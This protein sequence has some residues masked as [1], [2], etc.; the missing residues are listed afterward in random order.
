MPII[1]FVIDTSAS[2][3]QRTYMGTTLLDVAKGAVETFLKLR[4]RD[5][6]SRA[7]RYMLVSFEDPP[8]AIKA[9][10]KEN[11]V[12]FMNE[13][14]NLQATGMTTMGQALKQ[15]FDLL[16]LNRL[17][18]GIDNYGQGRNP[19]FLE[20]AM[21]VTI[22]DGSK[23]TSSS[24]VQEELTLP[25]NSQLPGGELTKEPFRWDQRLFSLV[26]RIP[27]VACRVQEPPQGV[28][29]MDESPI[30]V[31]CEITGGRSYTVASQKTL[32][33]CL[34]SLSM[35]VQSGVVLHFEKIGPDP[36]P[37]GNGQNHTETEG[38][39][40]GIISADLTHLRAEKD[41]QENNKSLQRANAPSPLPTNTA[42]H[43]CHKLI[44]VR[45]NPKTGIPMGHWPIP[46]AFWPDSNA[47]TLLPR[48]AHP[49]VKFTCTNS[50][51]MVIDN[52]PFDKY[53][54]EP[55]PLTQFILERK[56]PTTCWQCFVPSSGRYSDIGHPF[57]YLKASMS[58]TC[59]NLFIMPYNYP[60]LLPLLDELF[61]VHK[62]KPNAKWRTAFDNYL[63]SMPS[64][65][66]GPLKAALRR[67][68]APQLIPDHLDMCLSYSV[69]SY[70]KK[71]KQQAKLE[72]DRII[73]SVGKKPPQDSIIRVV[74]RSTPASPALRTDFQ[75]V[76]QSITGE[77]PLPAPIRTDATEFPGFSIAVADWELRTQSYRNP[78]DIPRAG[79]L[80]QVQRMRRNL[81]QT[82]LAHIKFVDEDQLHSIPV[83]QM[84]NYQEYLKKQ[85]QPLREVE[86]QPV[87]LHTFGNPFK[88]SKDMSMMVDEAD[89]DNLL[90][91]Q[92][93]KNKRQMDS[94]PGSPG[95]PGKRARSLSPGPY[96]RPQ[97]TANE[98]SQKDNQ[99]RP[100]SA[101]PNVGKPAANS[102]VDM[103]NLDGSVNEKMDTEAVPN[104]DLTNHLN[105]D[106]GNQSRNPG[107][108]PGLH[109]GRNAGKK[110]TP[111]PGDLQ[112]VERENAKLKTAIFRELRRP[113]RHDD[114][115]LALLE[116]VDGPL[117]L[118][119]ALLDD[120]IQE[121][122]RFK[123]RV[124]IDVLQS[125]RKQTTKM[126]RPRKV[127][128]HKR[129]DSSSSVSSTSS[130]TGI[131][132]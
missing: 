3:N 6:G 82:S 121:A 120:V 103:K 38:T 47:P 131:S 117:P 5:P 90:Q 89:V 123:R 110:R 129:T 59:V 43:S 4:Q 53:E 70:L 95:P 1:L 75:Q 63:K 25:M 99:K 105:G 86:P 62:L 118:R 42:W 66:M 44:Y 68:G 130:A 87:R 64:Y 91:G 101:P 112:K 81:M 102:E 106:K 72:S 56:S 124:L 30:S 35:K 94:P 22:T 20:P 48:N 96:R 34:D 116:Q 17:V 46:E 85:P 58:M 57:G 78:F 88:L 71:L 77:S 41:L 33:Q 60:V 12:A 93:G 16:N 108:N 104:M 97:S 122:A 107:N 49:M 26:L 109:D 37:N 79:L 15:A 31:L 83:Q 80:D 24:G 51:P 36:D 14:K 27:G 111:S 7:D 126:N 39:M 114:A 128:G 127:H 40:N 69:I 119:L 23:L 54:L 73:A 55:S 52:L 19:F 67:M 76:L 115:I 45:P 18:S 32:H 21:V 61:K 132:R 84:G 11:H 10:W 13:L 92:Q 125:F 28:I 8:A 9:G 74:P 100:A 29:P 113:G 98:A 50:E 65:Y 2:M